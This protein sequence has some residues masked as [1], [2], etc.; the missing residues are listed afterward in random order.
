[1]QIDERLINQVIGIVRQAGRLILDSYSKSY[2][3]Y[4]KSDK[5]LVTTVDVQSETLIIEELNK[6]FPGI[7][8]VSEEN[9]KGKIIT[10][11]LFWLVDPLDG[12][13]GFIAKNDDFNVN[14]ALIKNRTP[15]FGVVYSPVKN[16]VYV[17]EADKYS[18]CLKNGKKQN[19][20]LKNTIGKTSFSVL[21]YHR[22][23]PSEDRERFL[24][25]IPVSERVMTSDM[26]RF[27]RIAEGEVDIYPSYE[28]TYE[29]DTAAGHAILKGVG[30]DMVTLDNKPLVYGKHSFQNGSFIAYGCLNPLDYLEQYEMI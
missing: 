18:Y 2:C 22:P 6:T 19:I 21:L 11:D 8:I 20:I 23:P 27:A 26:L 16:K 12:T 14:I 17:G 15:I 4:T 9:F 28:P 7:P 29:W 24:S 3:V 13:D 1:M 30:G 10:H 5:T 25:S